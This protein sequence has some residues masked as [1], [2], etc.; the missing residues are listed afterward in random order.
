MINLCEMNSRVT[1]FEEVFR[2]F[3]S[4]SFAP[5]CQAANRFPFS[6]IDKTE[7]FF[8]ESSLTHNTP[9]RLFNFIVKKKIFASSSCHAVRSRRR[10][11]QIWLM[12]FITS[13]WKRLN[14]IKKIVFGKW[15]V[16]REKKLWRLGMGIGSMWM[17]VCVTFGRYIF[18]KIIATE[19]WLPSYWALPKTAEKGMSSFLNISHLFH[20]R[21]RS[22]QWGENVMRQMICG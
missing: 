8:C 17:N 20:A 13:D 16:R 9:A 7:H 14:T 19:W 11:R 18:K 4:S 3:F 6:H 15:L 12:N 2:F 22:S 10:F 5:W 1:D 21:A